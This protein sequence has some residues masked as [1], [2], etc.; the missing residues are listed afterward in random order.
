VLHSLTVK[1]TQILHTYTRDTPV[2]M[3]IL[4][5]PS[6]LALLLEHHLH[7]AAVQVL[8]S[9]V[10]RHEFCVWFRLFRD[11][12]QCD[13][14]CK[15]SRPAALPFPVQK[16]YTTCMLAYSSFV[17]LFG[18]VISPPYYNTTQPL[19]TTVYKQNLDQRTALLAPPNTI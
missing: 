19:A 2:V 16:L 18:I 13:V 11:V 4:L 10:A 8:H 5:V 1:R 17:K 7:S 14:G 12:E 9:L 3:E 6:F 15:Y